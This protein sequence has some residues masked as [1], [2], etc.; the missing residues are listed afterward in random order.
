MFNDQLKLA[1]KL[2]KFH[3]S[4]HMVLLPLKEVVIR[5]NIKSSLIFHILDFIRVPVT[6]N[7]QVRNSSKSHLKLQKF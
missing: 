1:H 6:Y 4:A 3:H 5:F 2:N 7:G